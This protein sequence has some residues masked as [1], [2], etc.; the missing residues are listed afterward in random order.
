MAAAKRATEAFSHAD[1]ARL[2]RR[3]IEAGRA[4]GGAA[5]PRSL[6]EAW[7][8]LGEALRNVGE[9]ASAAKALTE[10]RKLLR[11]D[12]IGQARL[13]HRHAQLAERSAALSGAVRWL[14]RGFRCIDGLDSE[15]AAAW[16]ARLRSYLGGIRTGEGRWVQAISECR[17]AIAEA[18]S[19]GEMS[20][21]ARACYLLDMALVH[22]GRAQEATYSRRALQIYEQLGDP[23]HEFQ[24]LN[25]LGGFAYY[26]GR[27]DEAVD[28]YR[29]AAACAERAGRPADAAFTDGNIGEILSDQGHLDDAEAHLQRARQVFRATRDL[30]WVAYAE[31][32][33]AR[34]TVRRGQYAEGLAML[35]AAMADLRRFGMEAYA[36]LTEA[37]IAEAEAFGGDAMRAMEVASQRLRGDDRE[38]PLLTRMAGIALARLG[39]RKGA[40]RELEHSLR[41]ARDRSA[42]YDIAATIDAMAAL[43]GVDHVLLRERDEILERLRI[44]QLPAPVLPA[45][46]V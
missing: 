14:N 2:Y 44:R 40:I 5:D 11:D 4:E 18:E 36:E 21:L 15:E 39:E 33:L 41:T 42:E 20:A 13:C 34:L 16:R 37:W 27:W 30:T 19:V 26:D 8:Q 35:E 7:E 12:P 22:L 43:G 31:A 45:W 1:A 3:A 38:R 10:A 23:E 46:A 29:R 25:N 24:V 17:Q 28:L 9:P 6:A 32:L